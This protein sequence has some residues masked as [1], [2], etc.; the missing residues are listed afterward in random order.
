MIASGKSTIS[1]EGEG[2]AVLLRNGRRKSSLVLRSITQ[3]GRGS[4]ILYRNS[5][6]YWS[7]TVADATPQCQRIPITNSI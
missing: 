7:K 1:L 5:A 3:E 6:L 2:D 4:G